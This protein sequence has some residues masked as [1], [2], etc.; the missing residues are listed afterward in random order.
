ML[1]EY[2]DGAERK[3]RKFGK[4]RG[5]YRKGKQGWRDACRKV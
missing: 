5:Q 2:R 3:R 4:G 1:A